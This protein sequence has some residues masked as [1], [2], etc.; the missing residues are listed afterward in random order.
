MLVIIHFA[1][2]DAWSNRSQVV[3][4]TERTS[5][6]EEQ[7]MTHR[8]ADSASLNL[9]ELELR[10]LVTGLNSAAIRVSWISSQGAEATGHTST[11]EHTDG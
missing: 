9:T 10:C 8:V 6:V 5:V 3:L 11:W 1:E 2:D 7:P 4:L